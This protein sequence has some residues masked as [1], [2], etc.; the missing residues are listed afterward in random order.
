MATA[1]PSRCARAQGR[2]A[3]VIYSS[4]AVAND[5]VFASKGNHVLA[6]D[7]SCP[8]I[9]ISY[10]MAS[11]WGCAVV[12]GRIYVGG[13]NNGYSGRLF[14]FGLPAN[15]NAESAMG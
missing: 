8:M 4:P 7:A 6:W 14:V 9:A 10:R 13:S 3:L 12:N 5:L 11:L 2:R 1:C 15:T